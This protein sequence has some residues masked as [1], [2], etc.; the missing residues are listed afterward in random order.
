MTWVPGR[1]SLVSSSDR[2]RSVLAGRPA[3][4]RVVLIGRPDLADA[5]SAALTSSGVGP[6]GVVRLPYPRKRDE[7][8]ELMTGADL[9]V[10]AGDGTLPV[11]HPWVNTIGLMLDVPT[12]HAELQGT[13]ATIGPLV[14]P[15]EG[16]CFLCWRMR[17][18]AC[19]D[20]FTAAMADEE[21]LDA[22][23]IP[24]AAPRP[25]L[26]ALLPMVTSRLVAEVFAQ[27]LAIAPP[28]LAARRPDT[29]RIRRRGVAPGAAT[30][31]LSGVLNKR[32]SA[33]AR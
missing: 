18:L 28:R 33:T 21:A 30:A 4:L 5:V 12:L 3:A 17:A 14:L 6:G 20:D 23:R 10:A 13:R 29:R 24:D 2:E 25:V 9:V 26:P 22:L 15:G 31:G 1:L 16:P 11:L 7:L 32:P 8:P 27:T 19:A